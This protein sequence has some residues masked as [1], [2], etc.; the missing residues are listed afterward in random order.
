MRG[1]YE[2]ARAIDQIQN[3]WGTHFD[4]LYKNKVLEIYNEDK[5]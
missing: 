1:D 4:V 2:M 5:E 3:R